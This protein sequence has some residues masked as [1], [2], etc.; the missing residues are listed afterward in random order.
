M[1]IRHEL[2]SDTDQI[3]VLFSTVMSADFY[4]RL[5]ADQAWRPEMSLVAIRENGE[6]TGHVGAPR[7]QVGSSPVL[8]LVP[9]CV[10]PSRRG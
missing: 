5:H 6:V 3:R 2:P 1:I 10:D 7:A 9:P 4:D 8:A